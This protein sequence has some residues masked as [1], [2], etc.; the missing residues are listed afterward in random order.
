MLMKI[1]SGPA[2]LVL[3]C[4]LALATWY[5]QAHSKHYAPDAVFTTLK[6]EQLSLKDLI[7]RPVLVTFWAT[8]CPTCI[9]EIPDLIALHEQ[10][11]AH[12]LKIIAVAMP[13]DPPNHVLTLAEAKQLP[14]A[15]ALDPDGSLVKA[16]GNVQ[17]TPTTFLIDRSGEILLHK[18]GAFDLATL[19]AILGRI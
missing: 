1:K 9:E 15:V 19:Q 4:L 3:A 8:D 10:F 5:W 13:Y 18:V 7:G 2:L 14:Y 11:K 6:G 17:L 16:F 12:G